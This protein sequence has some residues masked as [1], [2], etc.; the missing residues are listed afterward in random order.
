MVYFRTVLMRHVNMKRTKRNLSILAVGSQI[1]DKREARPYYTRAGRGCDSEESNE[2][3]A[4][5]KLRAQHRDGIVLQMVEFSFSACPQPDIASLVGD[6][7][8]KKDIPWHVYPDGSVGF[9]E[10]H[11]AG[12]RHH[13]WRL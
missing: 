4:W 9:C 8:R 12:N 11:Q 10:Q 1:Y 5:S 13:G 7:R 3:V 2:I 6:I